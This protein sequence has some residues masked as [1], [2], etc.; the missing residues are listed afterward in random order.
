MMKRVL[1]IGAT[2]TIGAAVRKYLIEN[3]ED[4]LTLMARHIA[5]LGLVD[6][7][8][9]TIVNGDVL[10]EQDLKKALKNQDV[11]FAALSGNLPKMAQALVDQMSIAATKRL[12]FITSMGIYDEIPSSVGANGNVSN[13]PVLRPYR[14]A[15]DIVEGSNLNYTIIRPGWFDNQPDLNYEVTHKGEPFGGHD[16]SI[17]SIADLV[18][19]LIHNPQMAN[20]ES[21]GINRKD[22]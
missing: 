9:E 14:Q 13:N 17:V 10:N 18:A 6:K 11:V 21:L 16:V 7:N 15:A 20:R 2:G 19:K 8:R 3:S 5:K 4:Q 22:H 12:I 1:I